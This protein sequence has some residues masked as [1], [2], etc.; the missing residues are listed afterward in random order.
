MP[1]RLSELIV[2]GI[3]LFA[4]PFQA[5]GQVS[6]A[7][8][9][10]FRKGTEALR[11]GDLD[12][13]A[14]AFQQVT[15][16]SPGFAEAYLN[17]GLVRVQQGKYESAAQALQRAIS[18][19]P[20][21]RGAN[22]F[23][24]IAQYR[25]NRLPE[26]ISALK[27]ETSVDPK[28]AKAFMWLGV[29][30]LAAGENAAATSTLDQAAKLDPSDVDILYH[31]GR[32]H[33]LV[34]KDSYEQMYKLAPNS[35]RVHEVLS[36]SYAQADRLEDAIKEAQQAIDLKP[37][38]PGLH[39]E[40]AD[41]LWQQNQLEQA[42]DQFQKELEI[43]PE[44]V[45]AMYKLAVVNI[46]RSK[47]EAAEKLLAEVL[48]RSP[49]YPGAHYQMGRAQGQLGQV[50]EAIRS[51]SAVVQQPAHVDSETLRQSYYQLAQLYRRDQK[52]E[53]SRAALNSFLRLKQEA[54]AAQSLHLQD[55]M[56]R[57]SSAQ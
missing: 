22:L 42:E 23:L 48:R 1:T 38:E 7:A 50:Q 6:D 25:E 5:W 26:A 21:L 27:R 20:R 33:M 54:D 2:F 39:E 47:P 4:M 49:L 53:E 45:T 35:W 43:D 51:F 10:T 24:G 31:R 13:A 56:K 15:K 37:D 34:S 52:P 46:E 3:L 57:A 16:S 11:N 32:A 14:D 29:A 17:L 44:S 30:E 41:I 40:L 18:L 8:R 36:Q 12:Q 9:D 55:K 19:S 28:N